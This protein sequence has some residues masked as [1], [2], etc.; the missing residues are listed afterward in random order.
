VAENI[1]AEKCS[2]NELSKRTDAV[3]EAVTEAHRL[4]Q[5]FN[6]SFNGWGVLSDPSMARARLADVRAKID[7]ALDI[8]RST[9]WPT[10]DD[11]WDK[12]ERRHN[13]GA[14]G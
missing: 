10:S 6:Y 2:I 5:G 11:E 14:N 13:G 9:A 12:L 1:V 3:F 7:S 4:L 8:L